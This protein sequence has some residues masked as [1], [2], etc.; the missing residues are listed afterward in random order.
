M[1][2]EQIISSVKY[3]VAPSWRMEGKSIGSTGHRIG[4]DVYEITGHSQSGDAVYLT[5]KFRGWVRD[6]ADVE[7][8][9][10]GGTVKAKHEGVNIV[11]VSGGIAGV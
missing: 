8:L 1:T 7:T 9:C 2:R 10:H 4:F 11:A 6:L 3:A 5:M